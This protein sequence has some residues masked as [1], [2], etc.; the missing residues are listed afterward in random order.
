M[1]GV[2]AICLLPVL[3]LLVAIAG[4]ED[5][6]VSET[7][8]RLV[9]CKVS[10]DRTSWRPSGRW[11][12][13][14]G[15]NRVTRGRHPA[16]FMFAPRRPGGRRGARREITSEREATMARMGRALADA[17]PSEV[18]WEVEIEDGYITGRIFASRAFLL[19]GRPEMVVGRSVLGEGV[20]KRADAEL[21]VRAVNS[22]ADLLAQ[23]KAAEW[24]GTEEDPEGGVYGACP[25]CGGGNP[26]D[27][28]T[29]EEY[30]GHDE[31]CELAAAIAKAEGRA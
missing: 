27:V 31:G 11:E 30:R 28:R 3:L 25:A 12:S 19:N 10:S 15:P 13:S 5:A 21:I 2:F 22:F 14:G 26:E 23:V 18:P 24:S 17:G 20:Q 9:T 1:I 6:G 4:V 7:W 16:A 8:R 29:P